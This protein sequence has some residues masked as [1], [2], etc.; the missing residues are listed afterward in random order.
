V[1]SEIRNLSLRAITIVIAGVV[2]QFSEG[3]AVFET[4]AWDDSLNLVG[5][6]SEQRSLQLVR[7]HM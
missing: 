2:E 5:D 3:L 6:K 4:S 7:L 1:S